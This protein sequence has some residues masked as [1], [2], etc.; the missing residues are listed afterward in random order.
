MALLPFLQ[1]NVLV[2]GLGVTLYDT[3]QTGVRLAVTERMYRV[4]PR[5]EVHA[6]VPRLIGLKLNGFSFSSFHD[7]GRIR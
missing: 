1:T 3:L 7:E 5:F 6:E 2:G 4:P